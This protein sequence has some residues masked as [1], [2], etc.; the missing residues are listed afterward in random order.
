MK[1]VSIVPINIPK[2]GIGTKMIVGV[3]SYKLL[4]PN[5]TCFCSILSES[6]R[7]LI[8]AKNIKIPI[9]IYN[10]WKGD[11]MKLIDFV[12]QTQLVDI[13]GQIEIIQQDKTDGKSESQKINESIRKAIKKHSELIKEENL[14]KT[15]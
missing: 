9:E 6:D 10:E 3:D 5:I 13:V 2:K 15:I 11:D 1:A 14:T 8:K 7:V 12:S 4:N